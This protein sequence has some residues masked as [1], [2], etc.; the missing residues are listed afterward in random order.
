MSQTTL[1]SLFHY[2]TAGAKILAFMRM[3]FPPLRSKTI[4][5]LQFWKPLGTGGG[6]GFSLRPDFSTY[7]LLTVFEDEIQADKFIGSSILKKYQKRSASHS[8]IQL[9]NIQ[10]HGKWSGREP[11]QKAADHDPQKPVCVL[12]RATIK[13]TMALK[14]WKDVPLVSSEIETFEDCYFS[15]G[16]GEWPVFMQATFSVWKNTEAMKAYAYKNRGHHEMIKKTR[17][18]GWYSEE[19]FARFHPVKQSGDLIST[20][21][22]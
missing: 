20:P 4:P 8:H 11:F 19:L 5:G 21:Q 15:K 16:V 14:F 6:N 10:A 7:G 2:Q 18:L 9:H 12:T 17:E 13:P 3:G 1:L 22:L